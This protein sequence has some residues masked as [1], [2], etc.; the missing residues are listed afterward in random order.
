MS[1]MVDAAFSPEPVSTITAVSPARRSP[2]AM[3][4]RDRRSDD[5][6]GRLGIETVRSER[7][8]RTWNLVL[9]DGL[10]VTTR[11]RHGGKDFAVANRPR[12]GRPFGNGRFPVAVR[13]GGQARGEGD[14]QGA[15]VLRLGDLD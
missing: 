1:A 14:R 12:N 8:H 10:E 9:R 2:R 3:K 13:A 5:R 6:A 7:K 4:S 11:T 15:A